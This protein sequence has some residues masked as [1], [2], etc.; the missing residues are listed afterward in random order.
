MYEVEVSFSGENVFISQNEEN[1]DMQVVCLH[2]DQIDLVCE[3]LK[4]AAA[5]ETVSLTMSSDD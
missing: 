2:R 4:Q 3:W 1:S 5:G